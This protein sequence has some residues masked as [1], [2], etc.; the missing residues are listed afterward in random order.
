MFPPSSPYGIKR[1]GE[2]KESGRSGAC[3]PL[4]S[5]SARA[6]LR[7]ETAVAVASTR[8]KK[9]RQVVSFQ[10]FRARRV[11]CFV[12]LPWSYF[13]F[14]RSSPY[15]VKREGERK[16][17]GEGAARVCPFSVAARARPRERKRLWRWRVR[18][19]KSREKLSPSQQGQGNAHARVFCSSFLL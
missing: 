14:P 15:G 8:H 3:L 10:R 9:S 5:R 11:F 6:S 4:L 12:C 7:A 16:E 17:K 18:G 19:A 13:V 2:R 1:E